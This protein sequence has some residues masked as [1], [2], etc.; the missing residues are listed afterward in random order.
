MQTFE[1]GPARFRGCPP[2]CEAE[3]LPAFES[4]R[5]IGLFRAR[6][7]PGNR[8][9]EVWTCHYCGKL[10]YTAVMAAPSGESSGISTRE[11]TRVLPGHIRL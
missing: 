7:A 4:R 2:I 9:R 1:P 10:H 3:N 5:E 6:F 11:L 8:V